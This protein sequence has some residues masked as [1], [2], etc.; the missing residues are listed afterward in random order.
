[1][2]A[3]H[4][5]ST[6]HRSNVYEPPRTGVGE[7]PDAQNLVAEVNEDGN[8]VIRS[9]K[10]KA[11]LEIRRRA[12]EP[13]T[14]LVCHSLEWPRIGKESGERVFTTA[15]LL[16]AFNLQDG[17]GEAMYSIKGLCYRIESH[18]TIPP[19]TGEVCD[20]VPCMSIHLSKR[21]MHTVREFLGA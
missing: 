10:T 16:L 14:W 6:P 12:V 4:Q 19:W 15:Q 3:S 5:Q 21:I 18:L 7:H 20:G 17:G 9:N 8:L 1:M 13:G 2:T 11:R